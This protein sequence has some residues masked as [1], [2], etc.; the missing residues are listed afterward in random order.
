MGV[1][2]KIR[3]KTGIAVGII[4]LGLGFFVVG[5][6]LLGPNST[7]LGNN[8]NEVGEIAGTTITMEEFQTKVDELSLNYSASSG[9]NPSAEELY[10]IRQQAWD[11]LINKYAYEEEFGRLGINVSAEEVVDM[12]QGNN[13]SPEIQQAFTN[14]ETGVFD[15]EQVVSYLQNLANMPPQQQA[16]WYNFENTLGPARLMLKFDNLF[17]KTNYVTQEEAKREYEQ[18]TKI[19]EVKYLYVPYYTISDSSVTVTDSELEAYLSKNSAQYERELSRTIRYVAFPVEPS[20]QDT[21]AVLAELNEI[22]VLLSQSR[23]DSLFARANSDGATPFRTYS[24]DQLPAILNDTIKGMK[25]GDIIGPL[26]ANDKYTMYK[27]AGVT[28]GTTAFARANHIL[29]KG[30][31]ETAASKN[32]AKQQARNILNEI[33]R[34]ASFGEMARIHGTDGTAT[35][36]GDLGWFPEGRMVEAFEDAVFKATKTGLLNDVVE[37]DFGFHIIDVTAIKTNTAYK[38]A[39]IEKE[40]AP[41]DETRNEAY[42]EADMFALSS[43]DAELFEANA[44]EKNYVVEEAKGITSNSRRIGTLSDARAV[45]IWLFNQ[46]EQDK[47][48]EVYE[49]DTEYV[50]AVMTGEQ[51]KGVALLA[52]VKTD[53][54][55]KVKNEKKAAIIADQIKAKT[56]TIEEIKE[57]I[58]GDATVYTMSDLKLSANALTG[59]GNAPEAVGKAFGMP[60]GQRSEPI[61]TD[62]GVVLLETVSVT[63]APEQINFD[64]YKN[65]LS[66][67][68]QS[69]I[70][71]SLSQAMKDFAEIEDE[72]YK[73]F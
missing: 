32:A 33:R 66:Q 15:K 7:L 21:A 44:K 27:L 47:V 28:E 46:A 16:V 57:A 17:I 5:G 53:V 39:T 30:D 14:P 12:V 29:F 60:A 20:S 67:R 10:G 56:G 4:A 48:S 52:E 73:F 68:R 58:T 35:R 36:G 9:R 40:I 13:V 71:F 31:D 59:V 25:Q 34:G 41:S 3:E 50:V 23:N 62:N 49:L 1:I 22:K 51:P 43:E 54:T 69:R 38:I 24:P 61:K 70:S 26:L 65:Q 2:N 6:D 63:E 72:R 11:L 8:T 19:A 18:S 64:T 45:V 42:R 37:T 55:A